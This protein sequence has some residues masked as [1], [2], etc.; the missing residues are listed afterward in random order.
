MLRDGWRASQGVCTALIDTAVPSLDRVRLER[1]ITARRDVADQVP[2]TYDESLREVAD[3]ID[4]TGSIGKV[5]IGALLFWKRLRANT[6]WAAQLQSMPDARVRAVTAVAVAAVRDE[7]LE[8]PEAAEQGRAALSPLPGF[9]KGDAL[10]SALLLA[11]APRRMAVYDRRAQTALRLLDLELSARPGRY[12]RYVSLVE[13]LTREAGAASGRTW[14]ARDVDLA[15]YWL[16][17]QSGPVDPLGTLCPRAARY[18]RSRRRGRSGIK[19]ANMKDARPRY[20]A[21]PSSNNHQPTTPTTTPTTS[22]GSRR[23]LT[24][25]PYASSTRRTRETY[26][27]CGF[28]ALGATI[29]G[30]APSANMIA[31]PKRLIVFWVV[32]T[33]VSVLAL[34]R[35]L[36]TEGELHSPGPAGHRRLLAVPRRLGPSFQATS[37]T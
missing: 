6:R 33:T 26:R 3:R 36:S 13:Q 30:V 24:P 5:D 4:R 32:T 28:R 19:A 17:G 23:G 7:S 22:A 29:S 31:W 11:A 27:S 34:I 10:A 16:G 37:M 14:L 9:A 1:L 21:K 18:G 2:D 12:G 35:G 8:V 20:S 15:L 25:R